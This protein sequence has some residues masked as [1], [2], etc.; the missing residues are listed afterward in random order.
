MTIDYGRLDQ[1]E[2]VLGGRAAILAAFQAGQTIATG[3]GGGGGGGGGSFQGVIDG[4]RTYSAGDLVLSHAMPGARPYLAL[5]DNPGALVTALAGNVTDLTQFQ[6]NGPASYDSGN[7][8]LVVLNQS[9]ANATAIN[10]HAILTLDQL[11]L[12]VGIDDTAVADAMC[13]MVLDASQETAA[14]NASGGSSA[15]GF[16]GLA[17]WCLK[18][19]EWSN[20]IEMDYCLTHG[21][22]PTVVGHVNQTVDGVHTWTITF[23]GQSGTTYTVTCQRDDGITVAGTCNIPGSGSAGWLI[24][25]GASAGGSGGK[26]AINSLAGHVNSANWYAL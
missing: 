24:G 22:S 25:F 15:A 23:V 13:V 4:T 6:T 19:D 9:D 1:L 16:D 26:H 20:W 5:I 3:G 8:E 11:Q 18:Q 10:P 21:G 12:T 17:G 7:S 2:T 14:S